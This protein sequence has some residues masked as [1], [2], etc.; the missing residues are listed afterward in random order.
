MIHSWI[1]HHPSLSS[2]DLRCAQLKVTKSRENRG[3]Q[4]QSA[5]KVKVPYLDV[6]FEVC[7]TFSA[8]MQE[9]SVTSEP[10]LC[11]AV[12]VQPRQ[13]LC[14]DGTERWA[15]KSVIETRRLFS[16]DLQHKNKKLCL[17]VGSEGLFNDPVHNGS[18]I[19][20]Y[21]CYCGCI[22]EMLPLVFPI[23]SWKNVEVLV[24]LLKLRWKII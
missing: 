5:L 6:V 21:V 12:V 10:G 7:V 20:W 15:G 24:D 11:L 13:C 4:Q 2:S 8:R 17:L 19:G 23:C 22:K 18:L 9:V 1:D 14:S 16:P 3:G